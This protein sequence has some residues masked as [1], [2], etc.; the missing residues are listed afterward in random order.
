MPVRLHM[1]LLLI[2]PLF[3]ISSGNGFSHFFRLVLIVLIHE[4]GHG[5]LV[6]HYGRQVES[7]DLSPIGGVCRYD[8]QVTPVQRA[9]IA[10][11]G[12]AAQTVLQLLVF[13]VMPW[14]QAQDAYSEVAWLRALSATNIGIIAFNLLPVPPLDGAKAW[15]LIPLLWRRRRQR[16]PKA[17]KPRKVPKDAHLRVV[18]DALEQAKREALQRKGPRE[19]EK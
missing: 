13:A 5:I 11:G 2:V 10:W 14:L 16:A 17:S 4:F 18:H 19:G 15:G 1:T 7:L 8:G 12:V 3:A 9:I 6:R